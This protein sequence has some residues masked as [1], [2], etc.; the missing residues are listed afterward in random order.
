MSSPHGSRPGSPQPGPS[1]GTPPVPPVAGVAIPLPSAS[2]PAPAA[3]ARAGLVPG[4][5]DKVYGLATT[6]VNPRAIPGNVP[7]NDPT[8]FVKGTMVHVNVITPPAGL[9][10]NEPRVVAGILDHQFYYT[11]TFKDSP[12]SKNF[13]LATCNIYPFTGLITFPNAFNMGFVYA[14]ARCAS[15]GRNDE[16]SRM[17]VAIGELM[18]PNMPLERRLTTNDAR[19]EISRVVAYLMCN[20]ELFKSIC[21]LEHATWVEMITIAPPGAVAGT[22]LGIFYDRYRASIIAVPG[23]GD[24]P[25]WG[26][27]IP[28]KS[29]IHMASLLPEDA[30]LILNKVSEYLYQRKFIDATVPIIVTTHLSFSRRGQ[31]TERV[32]DKISEGLKTDFNISYS[33]SPQIISQ[34]YQA[35]GDFIDGSTAGLLFG[36]WLE[37]LPPTALRLRLNLEQTALSGLTALHTIVR[38]FTDYPTFPWI[39]VAALMQNEF[40]QVN[41]ALL[42]VGGNVYYGYNK[43]LGV[44]K[45]TNFKNLAWVAKELCIRVGGDAGLS[46][47]SGWTKAPVRKDRLENIINGFINDLDLA[48]SGAAPPPDLVTMVANFG[49]RCLNNKPLLTALGAQG[50]QAVNIGGIVNTKP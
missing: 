43:D 16:A 36:Y 19:V 26:N 6:L 8:L 30:M 15:H 40:M 39:Q 49:V 28:W 3:A 7:I 33:P 21:T 48:A 1:R 14:A 46:Q 4:G 10:N 25:T 32:S 11:R 34:V 13:S 42:A 50:G 5:N 37:L 17:A 12:L 9:P 20:E 41:A 45:S 44:A 24:A 35:Y 22:H 23:S 29:S 31:I 27:S 18:A 38:A 2:G 47:Y